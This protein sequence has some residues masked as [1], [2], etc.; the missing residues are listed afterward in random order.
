MTERL[1]KALEESVADPKRLHQ[2]LFF[3]LCRDLN[4]LCR[5][6]DSVEATKILDLISAFATAEYDAPKRDS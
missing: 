1:K 5:T 3:A 2:E 4:D 6:E